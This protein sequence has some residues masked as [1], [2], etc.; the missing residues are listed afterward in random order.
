MTLEEVTNYID[1]KVHLDR[2]EIIF[3]FYEIRVKLN[4]TEEDAKVFLSYCKTRLENLG[5]KVYTTGDKFT[6][7][8]AHRTVESNQLMIAIRQYN[9]KG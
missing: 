3:T 6:Y 4:L 1:K 5:Y 7:K 9:K 2:D 8:D